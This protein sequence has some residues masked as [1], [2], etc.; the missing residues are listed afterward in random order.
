MKSVLVPLVTIVLAAHVGVAASQETR[1]RNTPQASSRQ[2]TDQ[3]RLYQGTAIDVVSPTEAVQLQALVR[4][5]A[6][7]HW[8]V[9]VAGKRHSQGGQTFGD[10]T[11]QI[12]ML[13]YNRVLALDTLNRVITVQS[14]ATWRT[15]QEAANPH[16]LAPRVMQNSNIFTV[17]GSMSVNAHGPDAREGTILGT[18]RGFRILCPDGSIRQADREHNAELFRLAIGGYGLFGIILDADIELTGNA[19]YQRQTRVMDV[20]EYPAWFTREVRGNRAMGIHYAWLSIDPRSLLR[21]AYAMSYVEGQPHAD[22]IASLATHRDLGLAR[23]LFALSR[24]WDW[25]KGLRWTLQKWV[26][27]PGVPAIC[28]RNDV[29]SPNIDFL[30][31]HDEAATDILQEYFVPTARLLRFLDGMRRVCQSRH[32]NLLSAT[33]RYVAASERP[34]LSY[35][36]EGDAFG[37]V[38]YANVRR[39]EAGKRAAASWTRELVDAALKEGGSYYLVY[40]L[41]PT[42]EQ[43]RRAYPEF[44][45]FV[46]LKRKYDP[47]QMFSSTFYRYYASAGSA[48][49]GPATSGGADVDE[50]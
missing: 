35:Q 41:L 38:I 30:E 19:V 46:A 14:G 26:G 49:R 22:S 36:R 5:A 20:S 2:V 16:R 10:G 43:L 6:R 3:G 42:P 28:T 1:A 34:C 32:V 9:S 15:V 7:N 39:D 40:Q 17:G 33:I 45:A 25:A 21:E 37:I 44:D 48:R 24:R 12:D 31:Y 13:R 47:D 50:R 29:L 8:K 11:L 18:V 4:K 27:Q 23:F